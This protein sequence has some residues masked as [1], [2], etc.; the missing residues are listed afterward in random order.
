M[1]S[2]QKF[3]TEATFSN[4]PTVIVGS[5]F[6]Q[7]DPG[8]VPVFFQVVQRTEKQ[9]TLKHI[10][11]NKGSK[12]PVLNKFVENS[13]Y[14]RPKDCIK[15]KLTGQQNN[16]MFFAK[17]NSESIPSQ[18]RLYKQVKLNAKLYKLSLRVS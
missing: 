12:K 5:V 1:K 6:I 11:T 13:V 2:F 17:G 10:E 14:Q 9:V 7:E 4:Y 15:C 18:G 16:P 8:H 3:V